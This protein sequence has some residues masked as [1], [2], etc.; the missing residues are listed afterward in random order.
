VPADVAPALALARLTALRK[1]N[2][3]VRGIATGDVFCRL[4]SRALTKQWTLIVDKATRPYQFA[5]QARAGKD[6]LAA[7]LRTALPPLPASHPQGRYDGSRAEL[8]GGTILGWKSAT[9]EFVAP[10]CSVEVRASQ[11]HARREE[12]QLPLRLGPACALLNRGTVARPW[13]TLPGRRLA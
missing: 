9:S 3:G 7:H 12:E 13:S 10:S 5:L 2:G 8:K 1:P 6:A 11:K 4:G